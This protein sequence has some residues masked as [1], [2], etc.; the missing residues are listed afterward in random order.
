MF[1]SYARMGGDKARVKRTYLRVT[2]GVAVVTFPMMLGLVATAEPFVLTVLGSQWRELVPVLR[3]LAVLGASQSIG[4]MNG[5]IFLS[6]GAT[7]SLLRVGGTARVAVM[8]FIVSGLPW[9]IQGVAVGYTCGALLV[10]L[11]VLFFVGRLIDLSLREWLNNLAGVFACALLMACVVAGL[12]LVWAG[13]GHSPQ[14]R[15]LLALATGI[16]AYLALLSRLHP[17]ALRDAVASLRATLQ[18]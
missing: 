8:L 10:L 12:D 13:A 3:V 16:A 11:P 2:R 18:K 1:P 5:D 7:G 14:L 15:L 6:Q 9:G 17:E 4:T